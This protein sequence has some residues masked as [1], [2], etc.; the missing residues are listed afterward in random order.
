[1][2]VYPLVIFARTSAVLVILLCAGCSWLSD[3]YKP[4]KKAVQASYIR[5]QTDASFR[6]QVDDQW[7]HGNESL[8]KD[9]FKPATHRF[10]PEY[11]RKFGIEPVRGVTPDD[12]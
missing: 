1:M 6:R 9:G 8:I 12:R 11:L 10:A 7:R 2:K 4:R 5:Y 3:P